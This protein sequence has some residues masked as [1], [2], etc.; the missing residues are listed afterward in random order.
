MRESA[1]LEQKLG[2]AY[3]SEGYSETAKNFY[4]RAKEI[5]PDFPGSL[6]CIRLDDKQADILESAVKRH[7]ESPKN[8][9]SLAK[10]MQFDGHYSPARSE[11]ETAISLSHG[12]HNFEA[13]N[14]LRQLPDS[15]ARARTYLFINLGEYELSQQKFTAALNAYLKAQKYVAKGDTR[16]QA[17]ILASMAKVFEAVGDEESSKKCNARAHAL[18]PS[19]E[20]ETKKIITDTRQ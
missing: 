3:A 13:E 17:C 12:K 16:E 18:D 11:L 2:Q 5:F 4:D 6:N 8:H 1:C 7:P 10:K 19:I 20:I 9:I 15:A 14:L